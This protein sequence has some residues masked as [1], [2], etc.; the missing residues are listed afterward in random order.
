VTE[1]TQQELSCSVHGEEMTCSPEELRTL[2]L[3]EKLT[4]EQ[5]AWLCSHART[6]LRRG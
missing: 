5:L 3:F 6:G 2:F 1:Q 4:D